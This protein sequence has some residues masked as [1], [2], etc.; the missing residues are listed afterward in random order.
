M[1]DETVRDTQQEQSDRTSETAFREFVQHQ[2]IAIE[3]LGKAVESLFPKEF[4]EHTRNA[5]QAFIDAFRS[6]FDAA[7]EDLEQMM[8]RRSEN[9][10]KSGETATKVKV[11]IE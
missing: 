4:R 2:R 1:S 7:R 9:K 3:E 8:K 6:L 5:G 10:E 11:E